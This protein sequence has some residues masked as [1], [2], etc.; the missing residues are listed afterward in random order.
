[1]QLKIGELAKRAGLSVRALHHYDAIA[2]LSPSVRTASGA[3]LYGHTDLIRLHRIL[4]LKQFGYSLPDIRS[5]LSDTSV[6]PL[7]LIQQQVEILE[8]QARQAKALATRL[9]RIA[10]HMSQGSE[11][12]GADWLDVL[13]LTAIYERHLTPQDMQSLHSP[14]CGAPATL[15][16]QWKQLIAQVAA[17]MR[18]PME[19]DTP[20]AQALAWRWVR[21]VIAMTRNNAALSN[22]LKTLQERD[23]RAQEILGIDGA[24]FTWIGRAMAHARLA[25][26]AKHLT[27]RQTAAL[28]Q[29]Q[30]SSMAHMDQWPQLVA[31]VRACMQ[32]GVSSTAE[33]MLALARRWDQLF[34]DSYCGSDKALEARIR[35]AFAQE[36]D[37]TLGVGVDPALMRY[38]HAAVQAAT[39]QPLSRIK[40]K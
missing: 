4:T 18:Q 22:K 1:M 32:A 13:E 27:P 40:N 16:T 34:R 12:D 21:L 35:H 33:P 25:L 19:P 23:P 17:A 28:R 6:K 11:S 15:N 36:P 10:R 37:L 9:G 29:R 8:M 38:I 30:L 26:F 5:A 20:A 24:M 31:Q 3:R 7:E 14:A 2:L 39:Q